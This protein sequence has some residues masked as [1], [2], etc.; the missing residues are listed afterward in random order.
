MLAGRAVHARAGRRESYQPVG[1][2]AGAPIE[3]A[4]PLALARAYIERLG[5]TELYLADLDAILTGHAQDKII[6][7][8]VALGAPLWL[9]AGVSS[10]EQAH[11]AVELGAAHVIVGLETLMSYEALDEICRAV[12][13]ERVA[14]SLDLRE[15]V[16]IV[17][18]GGG[19]PT[20][21]SATT[22]AARV[23]RAG[24][25]AL[26][27]IDLA[28]VG[29][30]RGLDVELLS[31]VREA[32]PSLNLLAGGGVRGFEDLTLLAEAGCDGALVATA[33]HDGRLAHGSR[34][35]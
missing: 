5:I 18:R 7:E 13:G 33:L 29:T 2:V 4:S 32:V 23:S 15:G 24:A 27:V 28:R 20:D 17:A 6:A 16:P 26:I 9:D 1:L 34:T 25:Q 11:H 8:I 12:G 35:R 10:V 30:D 3:P 22:I 14:F 19:I 21:Q 31:R